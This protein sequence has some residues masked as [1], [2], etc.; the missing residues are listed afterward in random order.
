VGSLA[1]NRARKG[2]FI[3]TSRFSREAQEYVQRIEQKVVL[4]DGET[5]AELMIDHNVGVSDE[6]R[7]IV[8]KIDMDYFEE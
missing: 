7:Y 2:V 5:L 4:I 3:T 6:S 8:K 1:G